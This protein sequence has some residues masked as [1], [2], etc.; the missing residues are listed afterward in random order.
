[1]FSIL[2]V[3]ALDAVSTSGAPMLMGT[4]IRLPSVLLVLAI[5][6]GKRTAAILDR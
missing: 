5:F 2:R 4:G 6:A 1:L 3:G